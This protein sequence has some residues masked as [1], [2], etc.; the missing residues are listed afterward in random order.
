MNLAKLNQGKRVVF[1]P[2]Q[3]ERLA[4]EY[5]VRGYDDSLFVEYQ[6]I[7]KMADD[8]P[9]RLRI[10]TMVCK[11]MLRA[12]DLTEGCTEECEAHKSN[13]SGPICREHATPVTE[14]AI[15]G[16]PVLLRNQIASRIMVD[17]GADS[18]D[19]KPSGGS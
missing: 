19:P 15:L 1:V 5:D 18:D 4:V 3:G 12:W 7:N 2:F 11:C 17:V 9:A 14:E 6:R 13:G 8:D 16:L 10:N